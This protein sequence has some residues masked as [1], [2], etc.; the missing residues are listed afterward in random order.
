MNKVVVINYEMGN[1]GSVVRSLERCGAN[2]V[3]SNSQ[4]DF[5]TATHI[6][7]P[8]VGAF[9]KGIKNI[10]ELGIRSVLEER[11]LVKKIPFLGIC[12]GMHLLAEESLENGINEGLGW[13]EGSVV[14]LKK[15][16]ENE[17]IP[18]IG[19]NEVKFNHQDSLFE[20]IEDGSDFYFV[21]SYHFKC[22][23]SSNIISKTPYCGEFTSAIKKDNIYGVQFHPE[24]SQ[25]IGKKLLNNFLSIA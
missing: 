15:N 17:R 19:W 2:A 3:L 24:K 4:S 5:E 16:M 1:T 22:K 13:I 21:H 18:H 14:S 9:E 8:G 20:E 10:N 25:I 12:L 11:V 23:N 6:V 7:L